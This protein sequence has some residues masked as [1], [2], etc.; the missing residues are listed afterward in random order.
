MIYFKDTNFDNIMSF[1]D[2]L[3]KTGLS[4]VNIIHLFKK[5]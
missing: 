4:F 5:N 1:V 2:T 3:R